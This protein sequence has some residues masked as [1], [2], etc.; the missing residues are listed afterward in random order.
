MNIQA[1][2]LVESTPQVAKLPKSDGSL[3]TV[4]E[5][6]GTDHFHESVMQYLTSQVPVDIEWIVRYSP[7]SIPK[8]IYSR[9]L[10]H[11]K[12]E[13]DLNI[14]NKL[15]Y[16]GYYRLDPWYHYWRNDGRGGVLTPNTLGPIG[17]S[18]EDF[19]SALKPFLGD[20]DVITMFFPSLGRSAVTIFLEREDT[21]SNNE[22]DYIRNTF[23]ELSALQN[24]HEQIMLGTIRST[25]VGHDNT[26]IYMLVEKSG[27]CLYVS[28]GWKNI[29]NDDAEFTKIAT[30]F[31]SGPT[32]KSINTKYGVLH[33]ERISHSFLSD[34]E[35]RLLILERG[36]KA[37]SAIGINNA[38]NKFHT[39]E[40]TPRERQIFRLII[41]GYS[42]ENIAKELEIGVGTIRN[43]RKR[44]YHKLDITA[45]RELFSKFLTFLDEHFL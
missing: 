11:V 2:H 1:K 13:I 3:A 42:N 9:K 21:F 40:L 34:R 43:H 12:P 6:V 10:E 25:H 41:L 29:A 31:A 44:L 28:K 7:F 36:L 24:L 26:N 23:S 30:A 4:I 17:E 14:V 18:K 19:Y 8:L 35:S 39:D 45:E 37:K 15:Y 27:K 33:L 20:M 5:R 38:L 22:I 32:P 16:D